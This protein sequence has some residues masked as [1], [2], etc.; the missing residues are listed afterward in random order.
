M[1]RIDRYGARAVLAAFAIALSASATSAE[2][3]T[4]QL[5]ERIE[6]LEQEVAL[7]KDIEAVRRLQ[8]AYNYYNSSSMH[9]QA[10]ALISDNAESIEIGGRG[11]YY[12]KKGFIRA[13]AAYADDGKPKDEPQAF[14]NALFQVAAMDVITIAPDRQSAKARVRVLTPL[15]RNFPDSQYRLNAGEYEMGYVKENGVWK[16]SKFKYV[17]TFSAKFNRDGTITPLYSTAPDKTADAP[18]TWYHPWPETGTL[19]HHFPN[20]VTGEYPP[21]LTGPTKYWIGNWPGEFGKTGTR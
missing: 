17:H 21:E 4:Q 12:G 3:T 15:F 2:V 13:F 20:P 1:T 8:Y 11:V 6:K 7:Q 16:I 19:K 18:T 14:G 9:E 10:M 5:L